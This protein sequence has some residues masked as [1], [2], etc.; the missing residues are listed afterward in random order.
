MG[1]VHL[2]FQ[3]KKAISPITKSFYA[4]GT[5]NT[6]TIYENKSEN[7]LDEAIERVTAIENK[8]SAFKEDSDIAR[9]N[10]NAG[11]S[12]QPVSAETLFVVKKAV[13]AANQVPY[14]ADI[15]IRPLVNLWNT[16]LQKSQI[17]PLSD[18]NQTLSLVNFKD[19]KINEKN[20][21]IGL[22][23]EHQSI[24]LGSIAKGYAADEV[25]MLFTKHRVKNAL[26]NLGGNILVMGNAPDGSPWKVGIQ[27]PDKEQG[28]Y[29]GTI[30]LN[31]K[32][33][34]TSGGYERFSVVEGKP[35]HHLLDPN[36]GYPSQSG[37]KSATIIAKHSIEA[38]AFTTALFI[39]GIQKAKTFLESKPHLDAILLTDDNDVILTKRI[40]HQFNITD[41]SFKRFKKD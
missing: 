39:M 38:D 8:M 11:F 1:V 10:Q 14:S 7:I 12:E 33:V 41:S 28:T 19:I 24:D 29:M 36:T 17:P 37:I 20:Q 4:L 31:N 22:T 18:I 25:K 21:T 5:I 3:T 15:T 32:T 23:R 26:I 9:V 35:Y 2:W 40:A 27:N 16:Y 13:E 30:A 34:V 6:L